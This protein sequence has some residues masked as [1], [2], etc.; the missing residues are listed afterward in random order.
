MEDAAKKQN[1][2]FIKFITKRLPFVT[3]KSALSLDGKIAA[4]TKESKWITSS[5]SRTYAHYLRSL[6]DAILVGVGTILQDDPE[7]TPRLIKKSRPLLRIVIDPM[8]KTPVNAKVC[9][10]K[11]SPTLIVVS[12]SC[13]KTKIRALEKKGCRVMIGSGSAGKINLS[14]LMIELG[15]QSV[16]S[17]MIEGG[18]NTAAQAL[19][20]DIVDK[21]I[22]IYAPIILGGKDSV[23]AVEG[24]GAESPQKAWELKDATILPL[25]KNWIV[26]GYLK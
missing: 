2:A 7:L 20:Q 5:A 17:V 6:N 11:K 25:G 14:K 3:L 8:G 16:S 9:Q 15:K 18:G 4:H 19:E 13:S 21:V 1:E 26:R 24:V 10:T 12:A 23:T 22:Y